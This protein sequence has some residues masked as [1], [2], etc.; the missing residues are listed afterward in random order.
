MKNIIKYI[1]KKHKSTFD[2]IYIISDSNML[3][4]TC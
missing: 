1:I 4:I 3:K 2:L